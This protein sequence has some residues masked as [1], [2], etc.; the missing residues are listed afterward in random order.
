MG[1]FGQV[2]V[3]ATITLLTICGCH[4]GDLVTESYSFAFLKKIRLAIASNVAISDVFQPLHSM[5]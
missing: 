4:G 2:E 3:L 5:D 1:E